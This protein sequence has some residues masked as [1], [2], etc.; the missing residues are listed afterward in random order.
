[1][2]PGAAGAAAAVPRRT[3][4]A[5]LAQLLPYLWAYKARVLVALGCLIAAKVANVS[6]PLLL[7]S[8]VDALSIP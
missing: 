2:P 3:D 1:M 5:T 8:L 7:K 4:W 6:V